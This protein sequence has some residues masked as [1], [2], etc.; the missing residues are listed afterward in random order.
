MW[1]PSV[2]PLLACLLAVG[3]TLAQF[4]PLKDFCRRWGHQTAIVDRK[5]YIDGGLVN[6]TPF[7]ADSPNAT[8]EP[9][10]PR[11]VLTSRT[12][13]ANPGQTRF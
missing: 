2:S 5:L 1:S 3:T 10:A 12:H 4:D 6:Y 11:P 7:S 13:E 8:S 9:R